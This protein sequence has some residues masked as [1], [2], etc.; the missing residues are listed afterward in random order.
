LLHP[1]LLD[2]P[3]RAKSLSFAIG[4]SGLTSVASPGPTAV[5]WFGSQS[6]AWNSDGG[7]SINRVAIIAAW[8]GICAINPGCSSLSQLSC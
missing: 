1:E 2:V 5:V 4:Y 3:L 8:E 6:L 7:E